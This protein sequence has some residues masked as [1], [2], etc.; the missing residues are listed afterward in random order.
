MPIPQ[1]NNNI[2]RISAQQQIYN[3]LKDWIIDGTLKPGEYINDSEI[4]KYF[5][6]SRT[7]VREAILLLARQDLVQIVPSKGTKITEIN[8]SNAQHIYEAISCLSAEIA[9]LAVRKQTKSD[10]KELKKL[11]EAFQKNVQKGSNEQIREA[12]TAFHSYILKMADN[13]YLANCWQQLLPHAFRYELLYFKSGM[14]RECSIREHNEI[15]Y[16]IEKT[17]EGEAARCSQQNWIGFFNERL[18]P[19]LENPVL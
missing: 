17:S 5:S 1:T 16:A 2:Q 4:A 7:P 8:L 6:V 9:R 10:I 11:N 13:P 15:I 14:D 12:D 18:K 19:H 3:T